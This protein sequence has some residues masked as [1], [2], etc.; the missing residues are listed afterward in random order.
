MAT[1]HEVKQGD[2]IYSIAFEYGFF[3][4]TIWNHPNNAELKKTRK[5]PT[6][7]MQGD[8]VYVPDKRLK[9]V[10]KPTDQMHK[11]RCKNTPKILRIQ[12]LRLDKPI[13]DV[14]YKLDIDGH[15]KEGKADSNGWLTESIS[16]NAQN[17]VIT[18]ENGKKYE[19]KL[20]YLDPIDEITGIQGRLRTLG[21]YNGHIN[22]NMDETTKEALQVFQNSYDLEVTGEADAQTK[23]LLKELTGG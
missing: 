23:N 7:L 3:A 22:G 1:R 18:L 5:E 12:F 17:A 10:S 11:F 19:L 8:T 4:D 15:E 2:C 6:V 16:P 20:G 21:Y 13:P 9:E 14:K